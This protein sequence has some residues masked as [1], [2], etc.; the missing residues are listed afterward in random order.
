MTALSFPPLPLIAIGIAKAGWV[1]MLRSLEWQ[2]KE[3]SYF[4]GTGE[5]WKLS[6][7]GQELL[8][9]GVNLRIRVLRTQGLTHFI[10]SREGR[11]EAQRAAVVTEEGRY[12]G[13][14]RVPCKF[15]W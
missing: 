7:H 13:L 3:S 9:K 14:T 8:T 6:G 5:L 10:Y 1:Q 15:I 4:G 12:H 11:D 2:A